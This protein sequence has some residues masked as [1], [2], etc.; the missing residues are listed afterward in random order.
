MNTLAKAILWIIALPFIV[1]AAGFIYE[2]YY[3]AAHR[4]R[5]TIEVDTPNGLRSASGVMEGYGWSGAKFIPQDGGGGIGM[6]GDAIFVDLDEGKHVVALLPA[7][8][9]TARAFDRDKAFW[10]LEAPRWVGRANLYPPLIPTLVTFGDLTDPKT[11]RV[12]DSYAFEQTFGAGYAFR[13]AWIEMVPVGIWPLNNLGL[14][15]TPITRGIEKRLP[16]FGKRQPWMKEISPG[17]FVDT[18][19][20]A[21]KVTNEM[22]TRK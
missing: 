16:W 2:T 4:Y 17:V 10:F 3:S 8:D 20:D 14:Y 18:R 1:L 9:V 19:T 15:G 13:R 7:A 5:L 6:R 11:A 21:F 22:F 12:V